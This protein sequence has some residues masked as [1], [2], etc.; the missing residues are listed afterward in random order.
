MTSEMQVL[1]QDKHTHVASLNQLM[2]YQS[3]PLD[4]CMFKVIGVY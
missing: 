2:G 1:A 4:D 3:S